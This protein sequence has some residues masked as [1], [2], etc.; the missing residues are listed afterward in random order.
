MKRKVVE[1]TRDTQAADVDRVVHRVGARRSTPERITIC[2]KMVTKLKL[3]LIF[4]NNS[5]KVLV[6]GFVIMVQFSHSFF[7]VS[8]C[9]E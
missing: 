9:F 4:P 7:Y 6:T 2:S 8:S 3:C 1:A 5:E